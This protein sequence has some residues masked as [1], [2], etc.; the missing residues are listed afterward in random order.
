MNSEGQ[1]VVDGIEKAWNNKDWDALE[2]NH[3]PDWIDHTS[4]EGM[5]DLNALKGLFSVFTAG[6]PDLKMKINKVISDG[7]DVSY[8]YVITGTHNGEFMGIPATGKSVNF[9]GMTMLKVNAGQ[10]G[11]AW[12]VLDQMTMMQQLGVAG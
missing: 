5:N 1:K 12:G 6:F 2:A 8:F 11:E 3:S 4:P 9:N 7:V 10:C